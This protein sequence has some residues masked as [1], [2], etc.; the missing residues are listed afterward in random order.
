MKKSKYLVLLSLAVF[1]TGCNYTGVPVEYA[2]VCDMKNNGQYVEV[3]G[4][5]KNT[6]S[7]MCSKSGNEPMR[8][9][10]Q[11]VDKPDQPKPVSAYIDLGSGA[12]SIAK[13]DAKG[14]VIRD[15]KNEVVENS[16][17]VKVTATL[18]VYTSPPDPNANYAPCSLTVKKIEKAQ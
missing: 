7:A 12:S 6:G 18:M 9:P 17:K 2:N 11:L 14:L 8:C 4:Y 16:Q 10:I 3:V 1:F 15:D 5:F 13:D